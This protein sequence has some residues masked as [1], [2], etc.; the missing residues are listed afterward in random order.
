MRKYCFKNGERKAWELLQKKIHIHTP[1]ST[2]YS[3][4]DKLPNPKKYNIVSL[5]LSQ[6][7]VSAKRNNKMK[8]NTTN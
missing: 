1:L 7:A 4:K 2:H 8:I 6:L 3:C 5:V